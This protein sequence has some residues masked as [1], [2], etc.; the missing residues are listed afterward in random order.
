MRICSRFLRVLK[1][2]NIQSKLI[3]QP[4]DLNFEKTLEKAVTLQNAKIDICE[5][6]Q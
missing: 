5:L 1:H 6:K 2:D 3:T 4:Y